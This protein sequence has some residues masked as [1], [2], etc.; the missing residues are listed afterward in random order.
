MGVWFRVMSVSFE[1]RACRVHAGAVAHAQRHLEMGERFNYFTE[2][3]SGSEAGSYLRLSAFLLPDQKVRK[4]Q[5]KF[6]ALSQKIRVPFCCFSP[7]VQDLDGF[8]GPVASCFTEIEESVTAR[9]SARP[10]ARP[11]HR[12]NRLAKPRPMVPHMPRRPPRPPRGGRHGK[13]PPRAT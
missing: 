7:K 4:I 1:A 8:F 2:L 6:R 5:D 13:S 10:P 9:G 12:A 11:M 3:C